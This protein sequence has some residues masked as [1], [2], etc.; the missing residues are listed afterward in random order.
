MEDFDGGVES[1]TACRWRGFAAAFVPVVTPGSPTRLGVLSRLRLRC[2]PVE[3]LGSVGDVGPRC[4]RKELS[5]AHVRALSAEQQLVAGREARRVRGSKPPGELGH[6][7]RRSRGSLSRQLTKD[8]F[9]DG[10]PTG[11]RDG[12]FL[13]FSSIR[14]HVWLVWKMPA[15]G[16]T[17]RPAL[18]QAG[19]GFESENGRFLYYCMSHGASLAGAIWRVLVD[20]QQ[21]GHPCA[22]R[23]DLLPA[24]S[25]LAR[26]P[27]VSRRRSGG[28]TILYEWWI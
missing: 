11:S 6:L 28:G 13:Y 9:P 18:P 19:I 1:R 16:G 3:P 14:D 27:R 24:L 15:E 12:R 7:H 25:S 21:R 10:S 26:E 20:G 17:S 23:A 4:R 2:L 5:A 8:P 22:R